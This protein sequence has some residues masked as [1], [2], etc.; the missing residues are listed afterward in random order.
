MKV[1]SIEKIM[2]EYHSDYKIALLDT[3]DI[4]KLKEHNI[5]EFYYWYGTGCYEGSGD[6]IFKRTDGKWDTLCMGHCS[7]YGPLEN[8]ETAHKEGYD[9]L[10]ALYNSCSEEYKKTIAPLI[11]LAQENGAK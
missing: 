8:L 4:E 5:E 1:V 11:E 7:C 2:G 6:A 10:E 9:T 3:W